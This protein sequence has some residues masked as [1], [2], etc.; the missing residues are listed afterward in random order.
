MKIDATGLSN[1]QWSINDSPLPCSADTVS[2]S[3]ND[4]NQNV[5]FFPVSGGVGSSYTVSVNATDLQSGKTVTL[6][7]LFQVVEPTVGIVS[8]DPA[9]II[10]KFLGQYRDLRGEVNGCP[11]GYCS[12]YSKSVFQGYAG[13]VLKLKALLIPS[14]LSNSSQLEWE[15]NG[16]IVP[17]AT[18]NEIAIDASDAQPGEIGN[19]TVRGV[20][21]Q[22]D[23]TRR[24]LADVWGI[25]QLDSPEHRFEE[26]IQVEIIASQSEGE[27]AGVRK[28]LAAF[29]TYVP[30]TFLYTLRMLLSG[31]LVLFVAAAAFIFIPDDYAS[32]PQTVRK[33]KGE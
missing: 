18:A 8:T 28:Y 3:C 20:T 4:S 12:N 10:P 19:V 30:E 5:N 22:D 7:R 16:K 13:E 29:G 26:S 15:V 24:A 9:K 25:S 32:A 33:R 11:E 6:S 2:Q 23:D 27:L 21:I 31:G 14:F 1:F 17:T